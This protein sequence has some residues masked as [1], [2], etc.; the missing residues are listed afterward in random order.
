MSNVIVGNQSKS[1]IL[2]F[3]LTFEIYNY[4]LHNYFVDWGASSIVMHFSICNKINAAPTKCSTWII[5]LDR[6][7]IKVIEKLKDVLMW[8]ASNPKVYYIIDMIMVGILE[9]YGI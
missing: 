8:L 9:S 5:Q 2:P 4:N 1:Q 6:L 7:D 3:L